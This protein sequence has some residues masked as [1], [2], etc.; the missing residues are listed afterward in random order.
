MNPEDAPPVDHSFSI[1]IEVLPV[2]K[3]P[4]ALNTAFAECSAQ[5]QMLEHAI[6]SAITKDVKIF[7][8]PA[9]QSSF[10]E[11]LARAT[12]GQTKNIAAGIPGANTQIAAC[13]GFFAF[14]QMQWN[15]TGQPEAELVKTLKDAVDRR[16]RLAHQLLAEVLCSTLPIEDA[17]TFLKESKTLFGELRKLI[18]LADNLSSRTGS[19]ASDGN[20]LPRFKTTS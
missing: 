11:T 15:W 7:A 19:V 3:L 6:K 17:T 1:E 5:A 18:V 14:V 10:L 8:N 13:V 20:S 2:G 9:D 12:L 16:N 4:E